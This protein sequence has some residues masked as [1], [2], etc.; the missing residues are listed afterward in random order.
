VLVAAD[1]WR[2]Q[3]HPEVWALI[4]GLAGLYLYA[5]LRIGPAATLPGEPIVTRRQLAWFAAAIVTLWAASDWPV[6]DIAEEHLYSVHMMQ[7]L[8]LSL[9][10][11]P[12]ALLA[13]PTWLARMVVGSG[14]TYRFLRGASRLVPATIAFNVVVVFS[15]WPAV[16]QAS[17]DTAAV[18]YGVHVLVVATS[19]LMWTGI[20]SPLPELRFSLPVQAGHLFLQS[21][22]PTVPAGILIFA[23]HVAYDAYD[24]A[25]Q[26]WGM[27]ALEDQQVAAA[28]MKVGG[29]T[30]LWVIIAAIF[31]RFATRA[32]ADDRARGIELDRRSPELTWAE[33]ERELAEAG[34]APPEP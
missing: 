20:V 4:L 10:V 13:T 9:V 12:M 25:G 26:I 14:R 15:H 3:P 31:I 29:A 32:Q 11:P 18:H 6:H 2:W 1:V 23:E 33:V 21:I 19:L 34:P 24:R 16:V 27:T 22:V 5:L 8:L 30:Y 17:I 7:H 28:I